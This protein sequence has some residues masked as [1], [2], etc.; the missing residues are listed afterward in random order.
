M[1]QHEEGLLLKI[2][3]KSLEYKDKII[4]AKSYAVDQDDDDE[5][6]NQKEESKQP[7]PQL[8]DFTSQILFKEQILNDMESILVLPKE[9]LK[10]NIKIQLVENP[11][12]E[13]V[14]KA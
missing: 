3:S 12:H 11:S 10:V 6:E 1:A 2:S 14:M 7:G 13:V 4:L 8:L 5:T 9:D